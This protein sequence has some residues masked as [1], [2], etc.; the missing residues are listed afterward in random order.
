MIWFKFTCPVCH[1]EHNF[2][3]MEEAMAHKKMITDNIL[4]IKEV[5]LV[6]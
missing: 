5:D 6:E 1:S 4:I 3:T 2:G